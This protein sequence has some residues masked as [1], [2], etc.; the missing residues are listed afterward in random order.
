MTQRYQKVQDHHDLVRDSKTGA[1]LNINKDEIRRKK[2]Q[3]L[4]S[5]ERDREIDK[6]KDDV[7]EIK[8]LLQQLLENSK[9][10]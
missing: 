6:L 4:K 8:N 10:G 3:R 7:G 1:I 9:H 5:L 2:Q